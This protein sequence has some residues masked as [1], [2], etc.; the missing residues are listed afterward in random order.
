MGVLLVT[1]LLSLLLV[2]IFL[3]LFLGERSRGRAGSP[4]RDALLPL[5]GNDKKRPASRGIEDHRL[6][7]GQS[8]PAHRFTPLGT[9]P[10]EQTH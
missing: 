4:E 7:A 9:P 2:V 1:I 8:G 6:G 5:D 3:L 10:R